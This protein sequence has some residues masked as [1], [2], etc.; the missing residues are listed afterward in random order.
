ME[1]IY[2][3][4]YAILNFIQE[5]LATPFGDAFFSFITHLADAGWFWI[6]TAVV[7]LCFKKTRKVGL[8]MGIALVGGLLIG[9]ITLKP[10][11]A[12]IRP[13]DNLDYAPLRTAAEL[14][15]EAPHDFS[16]PSGHTLA[17]F[18]GAGAIFL[19]NKKWGVAALV[20]AAL[21]A[22]SRLYLYVHY[23]T[24]IIA[25]ILIALGLAYGAYKLVGFIEKKIAEKN[26]EKAENV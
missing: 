19:C 21:I 15:I 13:Y 26:A 20:L 16:F 7:L 12:R 22:L 18:E 25:G 23:P 5:N 2:E 6:A 17:S 10:L 11:I 3:F 8:C 4:D 14:L 24:D 1:A 9:N